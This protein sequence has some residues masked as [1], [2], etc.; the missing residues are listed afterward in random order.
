M[1]TMDRRVDIPAV[2]HALMDR[3][4]YRHVLR[5]LDR[6][7]IDD[8]EQ[9]AA[10][11]IA[12]GRCLMEQAR[13]RAAYR[14]FR[15]TSDA[16]PTTAYRIKAELWC[17]FLALYGVADPP[18]PEPAARL[19]ARINAALERRA[20]PEVHALALDL[21]A[22]LS[23]FRIVT[24]E[25]PVA[26]RPSAA[27]RFA[28]AIDFYRAIGD[29]GQALRSMSR[30]AVLWSDPPMP[31]L[32][33]ARQLYRQIEAEADAAGCPVLGA[34]AALDIFAID[35]G[36][37]LAAAPADPEPP[38][39]R[40]RSVGL[41]RRL[42]ALGVA[43]AEVMVDWTRA[44]LML[45]AD[46]EQG[47]PIA[48]RCAERLAGSSEERLRQE[49]WTALERWYNAT[50]D[51]AAADAI[52]PH[53]QPTDPAETL[54]MAAAIARLADA[55]RALRAGD[56]GQAERLAEAAAADA[57]APM[58]RTPA[59][60]ILANIRNMAGR[61]AQAL[62]LLNPLIDALSSEGDTTFLHEALTVR[63]A[64]R[65]RDDSAGALDDLERAMALGDAAARPI[66][67][68]TQL[69]LR[70]HLRAQLPQGAEETQAQVSALVD[71]FERAEALLAPHTGPTARVALANVLEYRALHAMRL[72]RHREAE[73][74]FGRALGLAR[75][76][77]PGSKLGFALLMHALALIAVGREGEA[78]AYLRADADC[79]EAQ[80][81]FS[82]MALKGV[83]W[84][85]HFL[86]AVC[87]SERPQAAGESDADLRARRHDALA[88][89]DCA[90][91]F[92]EAERNS[93][94]R[95]RDAEDI[96]AV[97]GF[98]FDKDAV[99]REAI[100]VSLDLLGDAG[101]ALRWVER[102]R[103]WARL[104]AMA[105]AMA[106]AMHP[107]PMLGEHPLIAHALAMRQALR[108]A[109]TPEDAVDL[110]RRIDA[111]LDA[112][113]E[114]P[115]TAAHAALRSARPPPWPLLMQ[116]LSIESRAAQT[117]LLLV[118]FYRAGAQWL[119]FGLRADWPE[120]RVHRLEV[121]ASALDDFAERW[122]GADRMLQLSRV[123]P[124]A[125]DWRAHS[126]LLAPLADW[127]APGDR[128]C[129]VPFDIAHALPLH[130][131]DVDGQPLIARNPVGQVSSLS[132]FLHLHHRAQ[133][134]RAGG[135]AQPMSAAVFGNPTGD[136]PGADREAEAI[137]RML[138]LRALVGAEVRRERLL[139]A[140]ETADLLAYSGHGRFVEKAGLQ[141]HLRLADEARV[142]AEDILALRRVPWTVLLTAC[143]LAVHQRTAGDDLLGMS[144]ALSVRGVRHVVA[145]QWS[146]NDAAAER[147]GVRFVAAL[148]AGASPAQS[149]RQAVLEVR[150][151]ARW[152]H[153]YYWGAF[154]LH[155][156]P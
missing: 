39:W 117:P 48:R 105:D 8:P 129:I 87:A 135:A 81:V 58:V 29:L 102:G 53:L 38:D 24:G 115:E 83:L 156:I 114:R 19:Q 54:P 51:R 49:I 103:G 33:A 107:P 31:D 11:H 99:Y 62:E 60:L 17:G 95:W 1:E 44:R 28:R 153:V 112:M 57:A 128:V 146:V 125:E 150:Q 70:A 3:R 145:A 10:A 149:L 152:A 144:F 123:D 26:E 86:R 15:A 106:D 6:V 124:Q 141:A 88:Q 93:L 13:L 35:Y 109:Q 143:R 66:A 59:L 55:D 138:D 84:R 41:Q 116:A 78:D 27:V 4:R 113:R 140:L 32:D 139:S 97:I 130:A 36:R 20:A 110:L 64:A 46:V 75:D 72:R 91:E 132:E 9:C 134:V 122:L 16:P 137:A 90:A 79:R 71:D 80:E 7:P 22:R 118:L 25:A 56:Y 94:R 148:L 52:R 89:L 127:S 30:L 104:D 65:L 47:V 14:H 154:V 151:Q 85:I 18:E 67:H 23:R 100:R 50:G 77:D 111:N 61:R 147:M 126:G 120:P 37:F 98:A 45:R 74:H 2:A 133:R 12:R 96:E 63:I 21:A 82:G 42:A 5:L 119:L 68:A 92:I 40:E 121:E 43:H 73:A 108:E 76:V 34:E 142:S 131:L 136:L 155:G 69:A 101:A